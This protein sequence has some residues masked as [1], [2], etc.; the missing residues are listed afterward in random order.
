MA[1]AA[2]VPSPLHADHPDHVP[3]LQVRVCVPQFPHACV[4]EPLGHWHCPFWHVDP[5]GQA[6]PHMPQFDG[7]VCSFT[8]WPAQL[9]NPVWHWHDDQ[10]QV[11]SQV[12]VPLVHPVVVPAAQTPS[13]LQADQADQMPFVQVRLW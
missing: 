9:V 3:P 8:H 7:S 11:R 5:C 10:L 4:V 13:P 12:S 1:P 6:W 2:H